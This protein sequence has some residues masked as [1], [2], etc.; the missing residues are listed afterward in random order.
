MRIKIAMMMWCVQHVFWETARVLAKVFFSQ[1]LLLS[2][3]CRDHSRS[4][5]VFPLFCC[6]IT[7]E[8]SESNV[9]RE[10]SEG[11]RL[12]ISH[13]LSLGSFSGDAHDDDDHHHLRVSFGLSW[14][15]CSFTS[16]PSLTLRLLWE[17]S[18]GSSYSLARLHE[19]QCYFSYR[20]KRNLI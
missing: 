9:L 12:I 16:P 17:V 13:P 2:W 1:S 11:G 15:S 4:V 7:S 8:C 6:Y 14:H 10:E 20:E 18:L 19:K 3:L 5:I